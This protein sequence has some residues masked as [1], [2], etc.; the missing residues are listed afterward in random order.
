[1]IQN[2]AF[3]AALTVFLVAGWLA[4]ELTFLVPYK[5]LLFERHGLRIGLAAIVLFLNLLAIYYGIG[6]WLFLRD[7][8]R[9]L[10][11]V[12]RQLTSPDAVLEDLRQHLKS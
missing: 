10:L 3:L 4:A 8:G 2:A 11:H 9:K 1:V 6:R 5:A 7:T 12:D